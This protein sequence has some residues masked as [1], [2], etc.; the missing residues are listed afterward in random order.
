MEYISALLLR[1]EQVHIK[2]EEVLQDPKAWLKFLDKFKPSVTW[3]PDSIFSVLIRQREEID[4]MDI[5]LSS[6]REIINAGEM[7][8]Y[9]N[10]KEFL[11]IIKNKGCKEVLMLPFWGMTEAIAHIVLL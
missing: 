1:A 11:E 9:R 10:C 7:I 4:N 6:L 3:A 8:N 5:D 2:S